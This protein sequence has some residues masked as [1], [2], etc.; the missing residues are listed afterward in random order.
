MAILR[1]I[2]AG[3]VALVRRRTVDRELD[4]EVR[5]YFEASIADRM[6]RGMTRDEAV[7]AS[8]LAI[9]SL[10]SVKDRTRDAGWESIFDGCWRDGVHAVR[11][12]RRAPMFSAVVVALLALGIGANTA[13]FSVLNAFLL[14]PLPVHEPG[15]LITVAAVGP[16]ADDRA[17]SYA[18]YRQF[19]RD[20][21]AV[22]DAVA[23]SS[24]FRDAVSFD[25]AP[26]PEPVDL[27]W[28]SG[29]Y[30]TVLGVPA[31]EGRTLLPSDD[32][33]PAVA[34]VAVLS[35]AF[36]TR[37]FGRD[38]SAIGRRFIFKNVGFTVVGVAPAGFFGDTVGE[39]PEL[40]LPMT[41]RQ[42]APDVWTGH[43]TTWLR[44]LA[45]RRPG[46]TLD[47]ARAGLEPIYNAIRDETA[48]SMRNAEF[49]KAMLANRLGVEAAAGGLPMLRERFSAPLTVLLGVVGL[50]LLIACANV[51]NL[52]LVRS[53]VRQRETAVRLAI[54]A[55]S[56]RLIRQLF[57]EA[58]IVAGIGGGLALLIAAWSG[59]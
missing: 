5:G 53:A 1:R 34:P 32:Q 10:E 29:N 47:Q 30:F 2:L 28:V 22:V 14:R 17:F 39:A 3:F 6:R 36:W 25:G 48:A 33:L 42:G 40:W 45:R 56:V 24:R 21:R 49:R 20:G 11:A 58:L 52:M 15:E 18:A 9:G 8:R 26:A 43:S 38:A 46:V 7:R 50:V 51:A 37:R 4:E 35:D 55:G 57:A 12:L 54:G 13:I 16:S 31:A 44:I 41:T 27:K 23:T 59:R 19:A